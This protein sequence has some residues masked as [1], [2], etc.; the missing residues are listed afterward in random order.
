MGREDC[1][2]PAWVSDSPECRQPGPVRPDAN[3][4]QGLLSAIPVPGC[5][6]FSGLGIWNA[7]SP[8]LAT[9]A[10][11]HAFLKRGALLA[12]FPPSIPSTL[13]SPHMVSETQFSPK[14][15]QHILPITLFC[16]G[17]VPAIAESFAVSARATPNPKCSLCSE[18]PPGR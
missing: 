4:P 9:G 2:D 7:P 11:V 17:R 6:L 8:D 12:S 1:G 5:S 16:K 18:A 15:Q 14:D 13:Y 10:A 3:A